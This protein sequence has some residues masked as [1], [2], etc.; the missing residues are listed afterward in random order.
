MWYTI[1][2]YICYF[3]F[4][5][6]VIIKEVFPMNDIKKT[7]RELNL[8]DDFLFSK[9]MADNAICKRVL[10]QILNISIEKVVSS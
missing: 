8:E 10:E 7:I 3:Q 1:C 6:V 4:Y 5:Q 2:G 9:V